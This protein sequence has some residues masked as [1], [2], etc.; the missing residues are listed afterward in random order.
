[1]LVQHNILYNS[2]KIEVEQ[3]N[4]NSKRKVILVIVLLQN[5]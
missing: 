2:H 4:I 3:H 5:V 1:M